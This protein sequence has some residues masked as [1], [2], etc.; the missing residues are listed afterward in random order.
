MKPPQGTT[1]SARWSTKVRAR[2][3]PCACVRECAYECAYEYAYECAYDAVCLRA[4]C[5]G[6]RTA[7]Y[8]TENWTL[9]SAFAGAIGN[10]RQGQQQRIAHS[11]TFIT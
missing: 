6:Y 9:P 2:G 11:L 10:Q 3:C 7:H 5:G 4:P 8:N 1:S